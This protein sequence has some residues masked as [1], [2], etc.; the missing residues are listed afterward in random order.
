VARA[1][2]PGIAFSL[3]EFLG[4]IALTEALEIKSGVLGAFLRVTA[5]FVTAFFVTTSMLTEQSDK[6]ADLVLSLPIPRAAYFAGKLCGFSAV[7]IAL[8]ALLGSV[9]FI[10]VP[11]LQVLLWTVSLSCELLLISA[12]SLLCL[13]TF[14][15]AV[16]ALSV[17]VAFYILARAIGWILGAP[18][19]EQNALQPFDNPPVVEV[20]KRDTNP[21]LIVECLQPQHDNSGANQGLPQACYPQQAG[22]GGE[23]KA[24][25]PSRGGCL[26]PVPGDLQEQA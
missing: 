19:Q 9:L 8:A 20:T 16:L 3:A 7:A 1:P 2:G 17:V 10:Y 24:F 13:L 22:M 12:F 25:R 4:E 5:V 15:Q 23:R 11:A 6:G 14:N 21:R 26:G 18:V